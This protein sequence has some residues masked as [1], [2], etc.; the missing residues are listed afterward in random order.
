[1]NRALAI[2]AVSCLIVFVLVF[3]ALQKAADSASPQGSGTDAANAKQSLASIPI[4]NAKERLEAEPANPQVMLSSDAAGESLTKLTDKYAQPWHDWEN[5]PHHTYSRAAPRP[6]PSMTTEVTIEPPSDPHDG[7]F[8]AT[9]EIKIGQQLQQLACVIDRSTKRAFV[10]K[11]G[12]WVAGDKWAAVGP[13]PN[14]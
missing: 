13:L 1:M 8:L 2:P 11:D 4:P 10:F 14:R 9:I 12:M 7:F 3:V 5:S 6:V